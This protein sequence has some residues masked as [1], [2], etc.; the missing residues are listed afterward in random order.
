MIGLAG[1]VN[2]DGDAAKW[3]ASAFCSWYRGAPAIELK[4]VE[5]LDSESFDLFLKMLSLRRQP[6]EQW[7]DAELCACEL[8]MHKILQG[9]ELKL[10]DYYRLVVPSVEREEAQ[11]EESPGQGDDANLV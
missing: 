8:A 10:I 11:N 9:G 5:S 3:L 4:G 7:S 6:T 2:K 1:A